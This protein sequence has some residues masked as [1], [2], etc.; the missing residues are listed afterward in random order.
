MSTEL[1]VVMAT[2]ATMPTWNSK[3]VRG[4]RFDDLPSDIRDE[5]IQEFDT[6]AERHNPIVRRVVRRTRP[7]LEESGLLERIGVIAHPRAGDGLS[8]VIVQRR[9]ACDERCLQRGL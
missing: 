7:M 8:V 9:R 5:F 1:G 3:E 2:S 4:P 6:L